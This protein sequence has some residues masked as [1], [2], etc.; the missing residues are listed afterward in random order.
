[1]TFHFSLIHSKLFELQGIHVVEPF[2]IL[3][4]KKLLYD[5]WRYVIKLLWMLRFFQGFQLTVWKIWNF[6]CYSNFTW[7]QQWMKNLQNWHF[8]HFKG[9]EIHFDTI[10]HFSLL[11]FCQSVTLEIVKMA[12]LISR[13]YCGRKIFTLWENKI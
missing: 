4:H 10:L 11:N 12:V 9:S 2:L 7:N 1:M 8:L 3:I 5:V 6:F 13:K